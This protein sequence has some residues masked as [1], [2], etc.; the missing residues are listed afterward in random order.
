MSDLEILNIA[1]H[2]AASKRT[3]YRESTKS[4]FRALAFF[5]Q[6]N[7]LTVRPLLEPDEALSPTFKIM[8]SDLTDEGFDFIKLAL[9]RWLTGIDRG[10]RLPTDTSFLA[11]ELK[12]LRGPS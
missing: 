11:K 10:Q 8:R 12:K 4:I 6:D 7:S 3:S 9:D 5:L 2:L 1:V